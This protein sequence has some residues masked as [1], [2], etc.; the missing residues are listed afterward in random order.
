M[1]L[2]ASSAVSFKL[3]AE[4]TMVTATGIVIPISTSAVSFKLAAEPT[5]VTAGSVVIPISTSA[6]SFAPI[7][8]GSGSGGS[9]GGDQP[10]HRWL[11]SF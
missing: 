3:A 5:M 2:V 10:I 9:S 1:T 4:P 7:S 8:G 6:V 11:S